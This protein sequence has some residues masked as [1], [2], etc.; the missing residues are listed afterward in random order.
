MGYKNGKQFQSLCITN[1]AMRY[2]NR[3]KETKIMPPLIKDDQ[4]LKKMQWD[5]G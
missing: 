5:F 2:V 4:L 3:F 1:T